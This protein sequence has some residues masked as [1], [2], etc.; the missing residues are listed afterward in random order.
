MNLFGD[1]AKASAKCLVAQGPQDQGRPCSNLNAA[2]IGVGLDQVVDRWLH[3]F[4][5]D[6]IRVFGAGCVGCG[7]AARRRYH[8][9]AQLPDEIF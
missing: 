6:G 4:E 3:V 8:D 1:Q 2:A 9:A 5:F 7:T